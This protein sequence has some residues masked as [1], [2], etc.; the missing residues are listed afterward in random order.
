MNVLF[1]SASKYPSNSAESSRLHYLA[2]LFAEDNCVTILSRGG[3]A[4][5]L[6]KNIKHISV[7]N[8]NL[9]KGNVVF[10]ALDYAL[11]LS[12][13]KNYLKVS[14]CVDAIVVCAMPTP[15]LKYLL[16]YVKLKKIILIHDA[17]EWYSPE[18]FKLG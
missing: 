12:H 15:V 2:Q 3:A 13:V 7:S 4:S 5:N 11:F 8:K 18:E 10:R 6:R 14:D 16:T 9:I 17:V 1:I